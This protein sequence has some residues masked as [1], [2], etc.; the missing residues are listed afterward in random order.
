MVI[1]LGWVTLFNSCPVAAFLTY[2]IDQYV[3]DAWI[4]HSCRI[5]L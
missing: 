3:L 1:F 2:L 5:N 4:A